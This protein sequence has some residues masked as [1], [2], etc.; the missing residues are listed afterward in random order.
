MH[1]PDG[2]ATTLF[3]MR[4]KLVAALFA[5]VLALA[6]CGS[7]GLS[8]EDQALADALGE[9]F[10]TDEGISAEDQACIGEKAVNAIGA[11]RFGDLGVTADN[12]ADDFDPADL[13]EMTDDERDSLVG[14]IEGCVDLRRSMAD[15][16]GEGDAEL[17]DCAY[18]ALSDEDASALLRGAMDTD[19]EAGF[20][21][22]NAI[23]DKVA[24]C[25]E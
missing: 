15:S 16:I 1:P 8:A 10:E 9:S 24:S 20:E 23:F 13:P 5:S 25:L 12:A 22:F 17:A 19:P 3:G 6:S 21:Q 18:E 2:T 4:I 11:D 14:V 7:S